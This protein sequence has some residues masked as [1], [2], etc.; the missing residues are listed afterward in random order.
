MQMGGLRETLGWDNID[1]ILLENLGW[2]EVVLPELQ[3][4]LLK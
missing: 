3:V 4:K 1:A 2:K